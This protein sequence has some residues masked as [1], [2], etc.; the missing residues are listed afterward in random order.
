MVFRTPSRYG[1][2]F[3]IF[4]RNL[5]ISFFKN[6]FKAIFSMTL[7]PFELSKWS[8]N[9]RAI[10]L[11]NISAVSLGRFLSSK[12]FW[13][14]FVWKQPNTNIYFRKNIAIVLFNS[15]SCMNSYW[16]HFLFY[17]DFL[18]PDIHESQNSSRKG[19]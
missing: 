16:L 9:G 1:G 2:D 10:C 19:R 5:T 6:S 4:M 8:K 3:T 12:N 7:N 18:S 13:H 11:G 15:L 14:S 17:L